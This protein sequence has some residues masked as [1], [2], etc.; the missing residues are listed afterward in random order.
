MALTA[1]LGGFLFGYDSA[2][3]N[4]T[5]DAV[6]EQFSLSSVMLGFTVSCALLGA[7]L[8]A[9]FAGVCS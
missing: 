2:I 8:G 4:G 7:A 9:W 3:I 6:R 1:A 5:V